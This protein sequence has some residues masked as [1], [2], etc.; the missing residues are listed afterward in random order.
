MTKRLLSAWA[1][2]A[3]SSVSAFGAPFYDGFATDTTGSYTKFDFYNASVT[4]TMAWDSAGFAR[5]DSPNPNSGPTAEIFFPPGATRTPYEAVSLAIDGMTTGGTSGNS[6]RGTGLVISASSNPNIFGTGAAD[7]LYR[8]VMNRESGTGSTYWLEVR[9]ANN[10]TLFPPTRPG[11][12]VG[13]PVSLSI[14]REGHDYVFY[15][16]G[17][18]VFRDDA[19]ARYGAGAA[20]PYFGVTTGAAG[21]GTT[22]ASNI[23]DLHVNVPTGPRPPLPYSQS[24][25]LDDFTSLSGYQEKKLYPDST[26][27]LGGAGAPIAWSA[28][29]G[30]LLAS[31]GTAS[32][33]MGDVLWQTSQAFAEDGRLEMRVAGYANSGPWWVSGLVLSDSD[34]YRSAYGATRAIHNAY[35]FEVLNGTL[36]VRKLIDGVSDNNTAVILGSTVAGLGNSHSDPFYLDIVRQDDHYWFYYDADAEGPLLP[37]LLATDTWGVDLKYFGVFTGSNYAVSSTFLVDRLA[38]YVPEPSACVLLLISG[39]WLTVSTGRRRNRPRTR[40]DRCQRP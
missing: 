32:F 37:Q 18:E 35:E 34:E 9:A 12:L 3:V 21:P 36:Q 5:L 13:F 38:L 19:V 23:D 27:A 28:P 26:G 31:H 33:D 15:A 2:V 14:Q 10:L 39:A 7:L 11:F 17:T 20:L 40:G 22:L 16:D 4:S 29:S 30:A 8:F 1:V 24:C 25:W 6:W